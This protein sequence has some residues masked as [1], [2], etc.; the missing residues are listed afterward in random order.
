MLPSKISTGAGDGAFAKIEVPANTA[1]AQYS[2]NIFDKGRQSQ[3]LRKAQLN[4]L[5]NMMKKTFDS[6]KVIK[7]AETLNRYRYLCKYK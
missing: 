1:Y 4:M 5:E 7:Y 6:K 3:E 2:G